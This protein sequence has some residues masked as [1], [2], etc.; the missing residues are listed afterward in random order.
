MNYKEKHIQHNAIY[1]RI[2]CSIGILLRTRQRNIKDHEIKEISECV[3]TFEKCGL[4]VA[5]V[6]FN[7]CTDFKLMV[8]R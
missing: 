3:G 2:T 8:V 5:L 6:C 7:G 1:N 4:T